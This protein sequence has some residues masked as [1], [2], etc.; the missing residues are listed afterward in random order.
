LVAVGIVVGLAGYAVFAEQQKG[1]MGE[2]MMMPK[3]EKI[4]PMP[5]CPMCTTMCK[6]MMEKKLVAT[7]DGG[8]ILMAGCKLIKFDKDLNKVKEVS[9]E[10]DPEEMKAK[11]QKMMKCC[12][13]CLMMKKHEGMM[14]MKNA[15]DSNSMQT[16]CP[17]TG[18]KINKRFCTEYKGKKVY[19][20]CQG[21][22]EKFKADPE[23]YIDKLPQFKEQ[24]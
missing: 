17:I 5:N 3:D 15:D 22:I 8:I 16:V 23:K 19:F 21:C 11:M 18:K 24:E 2:G 10:I 1:Q 20:C 6:S 4:C 13:M 9:I 7:E 14:L 12:P